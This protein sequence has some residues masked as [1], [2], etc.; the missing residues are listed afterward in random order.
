M[1]VELRELGEHAEMKTASETLISRNARF[2]F[3]FSLSKK[4]PGGITGWA[5]RLLGVKG[6]DQVGPL[7]T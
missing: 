3:I 7:N 2:D 5:H 1:T 6:V 4:V